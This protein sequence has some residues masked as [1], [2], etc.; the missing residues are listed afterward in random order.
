MGNIRER[1][2]YGKSSRYRIVYLQCYLHRERHELP[3]RLDLYTRH[4]LGTMKRSPVG[5]GK[6]AS[7][8]AIRYFRIIRRNMIRREMV[9]RLE[10]A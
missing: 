7:S 9:D 5:L 4:D 1:G 6:R 3:E 10:H 2:V 8:H